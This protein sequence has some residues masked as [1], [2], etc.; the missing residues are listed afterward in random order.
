M[1]A[2]STGPAPHALLPYALALLFFG[3]TMIFAGRLQ[4]KFGPRLIATIGGVFVGIGMIIASFADFTRQ[5]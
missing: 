3:F 4:D 2:P 5:G 1:K